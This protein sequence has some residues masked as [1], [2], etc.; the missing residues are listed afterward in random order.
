[1]L[2]YLAGVIAKLP[3]QFPPSVS[4][5]FG[6][7]GAAWSNAFGCHA[8]LDCLLT[9]PSGERTA[10]QAGVKGLITLLI[11][12]LLLVVTVLLQMVWWFAW[13][14][15]IKAVMRVLRC[16]TRQPWMDRAVMKKWFGSGAFLAQPRSR[17][18]TGFISTLISGQRTVQST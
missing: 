1:L 16:V 6:A 4:T 8:C 9:P 12:L 18:E 13:L 15:Y 14:Y 17:Q 5:T 10:E 11:P 3:V 2:Q 7:L